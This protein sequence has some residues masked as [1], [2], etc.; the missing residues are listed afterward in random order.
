M[1]ILKSYR[2]KTHQK[3][4]SWFNIKRES[5]NFRRKTNKSYKNTVQDSTKPIT[6][7]L[8]NNLW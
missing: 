6:N 1:T 2:N 5:D 4:K 3:R 7:N 8:D